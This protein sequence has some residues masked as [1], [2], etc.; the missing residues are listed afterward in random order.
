MVC[1]YCVRAGADTIFS[2]Y[3]QQETTYCVPVEGGCEGE[4]LGVAQRY[5]IPA[6][7]ARV[8]L[9]AVDGL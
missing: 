6:S 3:E 8:I 1:S 5:T 7:Y 9:E 2:I 4:D